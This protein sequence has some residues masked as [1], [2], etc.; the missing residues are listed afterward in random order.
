MV[1]MW[2]DK[3]SFGIQ[4]KDNW[5]EHIVEGILESP[6]K[7]GTLKYSCGARTIQYS[8]NNALK[9]V[10]WWVLKNLLKMR[11]FNTGLRCTLGY[12]KAVNRM[13]TKCSSRCSEVQL[14]DTTE[15]LQQVLLSATEK[16]YKIICTNIDS[17]HEL[18]IQWNRQSSN[19][20]CKRS[21]SGSKSPQDPKG[22][23]K[24]PK[25]NLEDPERRISFS[26]QSYLRSS[27]C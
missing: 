18:Q 15:M 6:L 27:C 4:F 5:H 19:R 16:L 22:L 24:H 25:C 11:W 3:Q 26:P 1:T 2:V 9:S 21:Q 20:L 17:E 7:F 14:K 13:L 12:S 10:L 23:P 8:W